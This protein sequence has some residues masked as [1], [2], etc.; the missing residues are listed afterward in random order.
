MLDLGFDIAYKMAWFRLCVRSG[1]AEGMD[2]A[3]EKGARKAISEGAPAS[4]QTFVAADA[5]PESMALAGQFHSAWNA[6]RRDG[7]PVVSNFAKRLHGRNSFQVLGPDLRTP[8]VGLIC[9]TPDKCCSHA[10]R[11]IRTG[12][13]GTAISIAS[14]YGI[15]ISNLAKPSEY[16]KW[17]TWASEPF[18]R[19]PDNSR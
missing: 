17:R 4:I 15:P 8:S 18:E 12:G 19:R 11:T 16:H 2:K 9:W 13:T 3:F 10:E 5:T 7:T 6:I 14:H 1:E